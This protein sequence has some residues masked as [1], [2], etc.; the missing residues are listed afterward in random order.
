[1]GAERLGIFG[2]MGPALRFNLF[3]FKEKTKVFPLRSGLKK[4]IALP[5]NHLQD[6]QI[7]LSLK[8]RH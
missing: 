6:C 2:Y 8:T 4:N 3:V 1:L 5:Y 7:R